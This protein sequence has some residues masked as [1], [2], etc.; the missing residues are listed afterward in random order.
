MNPPELLVDV[1][2]HVATVTLNRPERLNAITP[3]LSDSLRRTMAELGVDSAVR[4]IIVT[5]A[6][7]GFCAGADMALLQNLTQ[8]A[9]LPKT[10]VHDTVDAGAGRELQQRYNFFAAVPKPVIACINGAA[11]GIGFVLALFADIRFASSD[12]TL[13]TGFARRGLIAEHG[14]A[15]GLAR[16][17][18]PGHAADLLLSSRKVSGIEAERIGLV[19]RALPPDELMPF[20]RSYAADLAS[21][22]S[23]RSLRVIKQQLSALPLQ[24]MAQAFAEGDRLMLESLASDD[25]KEGVAHFVE[26][27]PPRFSGR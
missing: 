25:F 26:K 10:M 13:T 20:T 24:T 5:G 23:P 12:A 17:V 11:A 8:G 21:S 14:C 3:T 1:A 4:V 19:N 7:R 15:F 9:T 16:L 2:D 18:G 6:D 27:R 22:C